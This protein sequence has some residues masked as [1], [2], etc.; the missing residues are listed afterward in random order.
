MLWPDRAKN[1]SERNRVCANSGLL[2]NIEDGAARV[3]S[4]LVV[5]SLTLDLVLVWRWPI[6]HS[7]SKP[8]QAEAGDRL[9]GI[10]EFAEWDFHGSLF[11]HAVIGRS[12]GRLVYGN[13]VCDSDVCAVAAAAAD[14]CGRG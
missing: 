13:D 5:V 3:D 8:A 14:G 2:R 12:D 1:P 7:D 10:E 4:I 11:P 6:L 9:V